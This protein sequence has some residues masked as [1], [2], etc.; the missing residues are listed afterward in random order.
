MISPLLGSN[1]RHV[2]TCSTYTIEAMREWGVLKGFW[3]GVKRL[4]T[5]H[6]WGSH[7]YDSVPKKSE[8]SK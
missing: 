8:P 4:S 2:P 3:L 6:P 1:C 5:C 7:G